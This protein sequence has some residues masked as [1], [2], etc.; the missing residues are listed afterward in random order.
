MSPDPDFS[1]FTADDIL[2]AWLDA[3]RAGLGDGRTIDPAVTDLNGETAKGL[4]TT[5]EA[6][7][8]RRR[9]STEGPKAFDAA[10][11]RASTRVARDLGAI[12]AIMADSTPDK[13]VTV[14]TFQ[15]AQE[16]VSQ[17]GSCPRPAALGGG[18]FC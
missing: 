4:R 15:L 12:C 5:I 13:K 17:H 18:P 1:K 2:K 6:E 8:E 14:D 7:L 11:F 9:N 10:A 16:L 3:L